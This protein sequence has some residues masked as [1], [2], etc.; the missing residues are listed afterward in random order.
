M[1]LRR[2]NRIVSYIRLRCISQPTIKK[3]ILLLLCVS[4][5]TLWILVYYV[6]NTSFP[7][8]RNVE[9]QTDIQCKLLPHA[10]FAS[11]DKH[12]LT[13]S[14]NV[15]AKALIFIESSLSK[16]GQQIL[17]LLVA[18]K[19]RYH[20]E[21]ANSKNLPSLSSSGHGL[22]SIIIFENLDVYINLDQ[23][24][25]ELLDKYCLEYSVGVLLFTTTK[26]ETLFSEQVG[27][28]PL[29][30]H[31]NL[32][33]RDYELN[34][35]SDVLY[36]TRPGETLYG[37]LPGFDWTVF[38]TNHSTYEAIA[39]AR[40]STMEYVNLGYPQLLHTTVL[41]DR[42]YLDGIRRIFFGNGLKF[43]LHNLLFLDSLSYLSH[44]RLSLGLERYIQIDIDDIFVGATGIRMKVSDV[45]ALI[46][47]QDEMQAQIPGFHFNLGFSG[48]F[49]HSGSDQEDDGDDALLVNAHRFWWF[50]HMWNHMQPHLYSN[51][52]ALRTEMVRNRQFAKD[53]SIPVEKFYSVAPHHSG[54]Y[55][56]H[57]QLYE[58]WRK[59]W[60]IRVT[61]TEEY[62]HLRPAIKRRGFIHRNIMV[63]PRQTCG[64]FTHTLFMNKYPGGRSK[65]DA[66]IH[67]GELFMIVVNNPINIF[68]THLSNYGNDRLALYTF[69]SVIK[70]V[71]C[72]TNLQFISIPPLELAN[73]YFSLYP[74]EKDPIWQNPCDDKRHLAIWSEN[75][76][77]D[78]LPKFLVIG[79]QKTGTTAL[80]SFLSMHPSIMSNFPST[81]TFEEVQFFS[82]A[83]YHRGIDW[84]ME[85]FPLPNN[86]STHYVFEKSATYFDNHQVAERAYA[87]LP[88][89]RIVTILLSPSK[90]AYS[91]YQH[92]RAHADPTALNY[93]FFEVVSALEGAPKA[94]RDLQNRCLRPG[95]YAE[96]LDRWLSYYPPNQ[97]LI[98]DGELLKND[99]VSVMNKVQRYLKIKPFYNYEQHLK[100]DSKKGFYCQILPEGKTKCLGKSKG[101]NYPI[102]DSQ[103]QKFLQQYYKQHNIELFK[104]L[105]RLGQQLPEWLQDELQVI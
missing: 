55:P 6:S 86:S 82:G 26:D 100:F 3:S 1:F 42:G 76:S 98:L 87:M 45:E 101:R 102:M 4:L 8:E 105:S 10:S 51:E 79:P 75:K 16:P 66:S 95:M 23:W 89:A 20:T 5:V 90:R 60:N 43:W 36:I 12:K 38:Q 30:M 91:W 40:T 97:L 17:S 48:K 77:C 39:Y 34:P 92:M 14:F 49:L 73:K 103:S 74:E 29:F 18:Q 25:R 54:V 96:H 22:F 21:I 2:F 33:L 52:T 24:N 57:T 80:Y 56:I 88:R 13:G 47:H 70:F 81:K 61:S 71:Q 93:S 7:Q 104:L 85:F 28:F 35:N 31:S 41:L 15:K 94:V 83:N 59:V 63:L 27:N 9:L 68:M 19:F 58:A 69:K 53:Y 44:G 67:G 99:P 62:P 65:L 50:P 64:L 84:Y 11:Q 72:W 37:Y 46:Q 78:R 32:G